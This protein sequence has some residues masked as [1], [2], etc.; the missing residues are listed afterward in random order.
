MYHF[1]LICA[2]Y[3]K[4]TKLGKRW[5]SEEENYKMIEE[6]AYLGALCLVVFS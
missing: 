3:I 6:I 5:R 2:V 4:N 1:V